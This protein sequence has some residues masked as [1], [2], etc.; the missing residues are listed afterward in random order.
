[1][2]FKVNSG[3]KVS[4]ASHLGLV[5]FAQAHGKLQ[6]EETIDPYQFGR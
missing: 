5:E 2:K 1:M 3:D 6:L 4:H